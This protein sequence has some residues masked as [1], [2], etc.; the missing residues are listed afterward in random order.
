MG[1]GL[2]ELQKTILRRALSNRLR[3]EAKAAE[4]AQQGCKSE[5]CELDV[6]SCEVAAD[7]FGWPLPGVG[8]CGEHAVSPEQFYRWA[9]REETQ[10]FP[11]RLYEC[12]N[13][14][15]KSRSPTSVPQREAKRV[16]AAIS[17]AFLQLQDRGLAERKTGRSHWTG[18]NLT[19]SGV[20]VARSLK[21][22]GVVT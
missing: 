12:R 16:H 18:I 8:H 9:W 21:V 13:E 4:A 2:S 14:Y 7:Y 11:K 1:H 20:E 15:R 17:Y 10:W 5:P 6:F 22:N 19:E 3:A